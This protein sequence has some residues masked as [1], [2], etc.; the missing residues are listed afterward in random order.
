[1]WQ[2]FTHLNPEGNEK[3]CKICSHV[4]KSASS[5]TTAMVF[6]LQTMHDILPSTS[7]DAGGDDAVFGLAP[8]G[9]TS[10]LLKQSSILP[11]TLPN[12]IYEE[13]VT[14]Q[15]VQDG[16][17]LRQISSSEFQA[18]AFRAMKLNQAK[19]HR[20][21]GQIVMAFI[22]GMMVETKRVLAL[23]IE[24][25]ERFSV[26]ADEWTSL[27]NRQYLNVIVT[28]SSYSANLALVRCKGSVT[29]KAVADMIRVSY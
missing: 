15:V 8:Q 25:G 27:R 19:S 14:L 23:K 6:H 9:S 5:S 13:W 18:A 17:T 28:S 2:H 26:L 1:V 3:K 22:I 7:A 21:V 12:R 4:N 11:A 29:A 10:K 24:G 20:K 16:L